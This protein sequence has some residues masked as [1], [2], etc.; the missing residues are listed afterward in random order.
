M[1]MYIFQYCTGG[2]CSEVEKAQKARK[3][4]EPTIFSKIIDK[5]IPADII[6]EDDQVHISWDLLDS[7]T[8]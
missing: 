7:L 2:D 8:A 6:Y 1:Y 5:T 4:A 3:S